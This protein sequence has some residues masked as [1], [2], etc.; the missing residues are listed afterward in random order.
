MKKHKN[1]SVIHGI[2]EDELERNIRMQKRYLD[3]ISKL[4]KGSI[5]LRQIGNKKYY[6]LKYRIDE[7]VITEYLGKYDE[8]DV[9]DIAE[10]ISKRKYLENTVKN[11]KNENI[12]ILKA[13][14]QGV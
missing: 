12:N 9:S 11:L 5:M 2:L 13:L 1:I 14:K 10:K 6:Y 4:P 7:K 8:Y 3:E